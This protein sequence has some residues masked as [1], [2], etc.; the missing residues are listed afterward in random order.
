LKKPGFRPRWIQGYDPEVYHKGRTLK[1]KGE[2]ELALAKAQ[3]TDA[4]RAMQARKAVVT[5]EESLKENKN[6]S[7]KVVPLLEEARRLAGVR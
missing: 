3:K 7:R 2:L 4:A 6:L 1:V 5:F